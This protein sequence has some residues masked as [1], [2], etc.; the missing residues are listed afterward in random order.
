MAIGHST[1]DP[2][3]DVFPHEKLDEALAKIKSRQ[4]F[5]IL[6]IFI[7]HCVPEP[8][9]VS[10]TI[11]NAGEAIRHHIGCRR[12]IFSTR[13]VMT[14]EATHGNSGWLR[15]VRIRIRVRDRHEISIPTIQA[16]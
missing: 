3:K 12:L 8:V 4:M 2:S 10:A 9:D 6:T 7:P 15:V 1:Q 5:G 13:P 16:T 11:I 14:C